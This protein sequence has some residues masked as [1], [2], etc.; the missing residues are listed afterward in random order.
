MVACDTSNVTE[1]VRFPSLAPILTRIAKQMHLS[2]I[3]IPLVMGV[4]YASLV[5]VET[6]YFGKVESRVRFPHEAPICDSYKKSVNG[7]RFILRD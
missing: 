2:A 6:R 4:R 1:R 5:L 7:G 3:T